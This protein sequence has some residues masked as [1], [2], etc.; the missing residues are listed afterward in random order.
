M[1]CFVIMPYNEDFD[2]VYQ[3]N[4]DAAAE[5]NGTV[6]CFRHDDDHQAGRKLGRLED[7]IRATDICIADLSGGN[8][9]VMWEVG[10]A[11][12]LDKSV[13]LISQGQEALPFDVQDVHHIIYNRKRLRDS[14]TVKMKASL[15]DTV[16]SIKDRVPEVDL[17]ELVASLV[18]KEMFA[19]SIEPAAPPIANAWDPSKFE[20]AWVEAPTGSHAYSRIINGQLI[21]PYCYGADDHLM[22]VYYDWRTTGEYIF[23]RY[24]WTAEAIAGFAFLK[25][26]SSDLL[27]GAWWFDHEAESDS[28]NMPK[29]DS[30]W[31]TQ[32]KR[33][34]TA[35]TPAWA[36]AFFADVRSRGLAQA[37]RSP[38]A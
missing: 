33:S 34:S 32:W 4:C 18:R 8:C 30:G 17:R 1:K 36:E 26:E 23:A 7:A 13:I 29:F 28:E 12:A 15:A 24:A 19:S 38:K 3:A 16:K 9:N 20:G 35:K 14:L 6:Q 37:L 10:Y 27:T 31:S 2:D 5:L 21:T 11:M 22:G 25:V